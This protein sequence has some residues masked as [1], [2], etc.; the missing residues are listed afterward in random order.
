MAEYFYYIKKL[1]L[2]VCQFLALNDISHLG[3]GTDPMN[4]SSSYKDYKKSGVG[5]HPG[6]YGMAN[7]ANSIYAVF[8][9]IQH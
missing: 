6:D 5:S 4:F 3:D 9:A 7:I 2:A 1:S 8:N